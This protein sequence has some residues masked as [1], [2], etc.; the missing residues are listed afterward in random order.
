VDAGHD[1]F[2]IFF[3]LVFVVSGSDHSVGAQVELD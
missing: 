3:D 2:A 1:W